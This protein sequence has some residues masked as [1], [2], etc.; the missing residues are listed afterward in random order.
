MFTRR[1]SLEGI[2]NVAYSPSLA[3]TCTAAPALRAIW[4][5]LPGRSSTL[6][7]TV[8]SGMFLSGRALPGRMSAVAPATIE[9]PTFSPSGCR[10]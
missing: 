2:R 1:T 8:P 3:T 6:C 10:M 4:P 5:P 7:T 9:S